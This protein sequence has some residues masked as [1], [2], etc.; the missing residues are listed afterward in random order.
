MAV[1]SDIPLHKHIQLSS[2]KGITLEELIFDERGNTVLMI[3]QIA[4]VKVE[5][6]MIIFSPALNMKLA[7]YKRRGDSAMVCSLHVSEVGL[8]KLSE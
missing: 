5:C 4:C 7:P 1:S 6:R 3:S 2:S 8:K